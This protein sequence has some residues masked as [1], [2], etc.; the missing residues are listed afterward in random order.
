MLKVLIM[1]LALL[2]NVK[3]AVAEI[4]PELQ[5]FEYLEEL[6]PED[7]F[8]SLGERAKQGVRSMQKNIIPQIIENIPEVAAYNI[9]NPEQVFCYHVE[10][11]TKGD[12]S[13]SLGNYK[14]VDY[15][16]ELD[17]DVITTSYEALFTRSPNI[18]TTKANCRIEPQVMLRFVRGVDF[19]DVLLSSP[20]P[21][22][23]I[24]YGGKYKSFN[25]KQAVMDDVIGQFDKT[26]EVFLSPAIV[27]QTVANAEAKDEDEAYVLEKQ[28]K[29]VEDQKVKEVEE[30][31]EPQ[32]PKTGW[33]NLKLKM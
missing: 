24:F 7:E 16:G 13:Y 28:Q 9:H 5:G 25:V 3:G 20:C 17:Y 18:I 8:N 6:L 33:G 22:F 11:R 4:P 19:V 1:M 2:I 30:N 15:C 29:E 23:T 26:R 32:K 27:K 10:K 21:S 14:I 31:K 12:E